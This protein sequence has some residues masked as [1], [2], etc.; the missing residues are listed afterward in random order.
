MSFNECGSKEG[1][2]LF[3]PWCFQFSHLLALTIT[4]QWLWEKD[5]LLA[6]ERSPEVSAHICAAGN[7]ILDVFFGSDSAVAFAI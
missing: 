7:C 2:M 1:F 3:L 5:V 4:S 6:S